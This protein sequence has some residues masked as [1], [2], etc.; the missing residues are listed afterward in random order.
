MSA[1]KLDMLFLVIFVR[2][3]FGQLLQNYGIL[4]QFFRVSNGKS[5][6]VLQLFWT[7]FFYTQFDQKSFKLQNKTKKLPTSTC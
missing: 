3:P 7:L 2:A 6:R 1:D 5:V 4:I